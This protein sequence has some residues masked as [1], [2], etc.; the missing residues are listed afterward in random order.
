MD[1]SGCLK[2]LPDEELQQLD[3]PVKKEFVDP[4]KKLIYI[5]ESDTPDGIQSRQRMDT[6]RF[7]LF[8][9][10]Q[11]FEQREHSFKIVCLASWSF[12]FLVKQN[13]NSLLI[14]T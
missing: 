3:I 1:L 2:L 11:S 9:G 6:T 8:T 4:I 13:W 5:T 12:F 14:D 7:N 10:N